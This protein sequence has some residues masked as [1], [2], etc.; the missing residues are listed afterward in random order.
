[1]EALIGIICYTDSIR[2][3]IVR[4]VSKRGIE[5]NVLAMSGWYF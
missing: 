2:S 1:M 4:Q 3:N 5:L